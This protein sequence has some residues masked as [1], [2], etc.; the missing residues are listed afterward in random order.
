MVRGSLASANATLRA[1]MKRASSPPD[2]ILDIGPAGIPGFVLA[3]NCTLSIP[4]A[5]PIEGVT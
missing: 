2:A 1:N 3:I 4:V 5:E